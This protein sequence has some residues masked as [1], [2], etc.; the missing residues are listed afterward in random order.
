MSNTAN[1][2][3]LADEYSFNNVSLSV[4]HFTILSYQLM[5]LWMWPSVFIYLKLFSKLLHSLLL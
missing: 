2:F 5:S 3:M 4:Y 1:N